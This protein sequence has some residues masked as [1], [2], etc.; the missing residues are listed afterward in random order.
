MITSAGSGYSRRGDL[1][2]TRWREDA[3]C[4]DWGSYLYLRDVESG[5]FWSAAWQPTGVVPDSYEVTFTEDR[6]EFVR[7]DGTLTTSLEWWCPPKTMPKC[8]GSRWPIRGR[9][10]AVIEFT[11]YAEIVLAPPAADQAHPA[12]S[13]LFVETEY[14]AQSGVIL[15]TRRRR[16]P[17]EPEVWAAHLAVI[18]GKTVGAL[19]VETDR[20]RFIGRGRSVRSPLGLA[21]ER[22]ARQLGRG[23]ARR[24]LR[25]APAAAYR[26]GRDGS[27]RLLDHRRRFACTTAGSGGQAS[28][29]RLVCT[30]GDA[31]LDPGAGAVAP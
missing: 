7:R 21:D 17:D 28:R 24:G 22:R 26:A 23:R 4:D 1:A 5:E 9:G 2:V 3:T 6:A 19:E 16:A 14:L 13:K 11:S 15:A 29:R 12:F 18:E 8:G 25:D 30:R 20:A 27:D 31:R 10:R